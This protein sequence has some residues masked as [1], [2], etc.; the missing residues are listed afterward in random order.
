[1]AQLRAGRVA[2]Q[3][4]EPPDVKVTVPVAPAG[5]P[6]TETLSLVP[7]GMLAG[8]ALSVIEVLALVMVK[9]APVAVALL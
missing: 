7:N 8:A 4:V 2:T 5:S 1:V 6:V 3:S 9:L